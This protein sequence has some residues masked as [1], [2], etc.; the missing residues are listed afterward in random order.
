M[1]TKKKKRFR[2]QLKCFSFEIN[3]IPQFGTMFGRN[4]WDLFMQAGSFSFDHPALKL[5]GG[6]PKSR[7]GDAN[8]RVPPTI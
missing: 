3:F 1:K 6:T 4:L 7:W 2:Q 5:D 8:S